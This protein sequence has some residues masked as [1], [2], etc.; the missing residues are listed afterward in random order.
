MLK[1]VFLS[2]VVCCNHAESPTAKY[3]GGS[4]IVDPNG[5]IVL[6]L[7]LFDEAVIN[8]EIDLSYIKEIRKIRP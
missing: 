5:D 7:P 6:E 4:H 2:Y 1:T 8:F 3:F